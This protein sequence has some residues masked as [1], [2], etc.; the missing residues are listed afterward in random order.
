MSQKEKM[1]IM[2]VDDE[3]IILDS[4][5]KHFRNEDQYNVRTS[6]TVEEALEMIKEKPVDIIL[7]DLMMPEID[8]LEF[9]KMFKQDNPN[10]IMIMITGYAT[11]NSALQAMQVGAFDYIAKPFTREEL[12]KVIARAAEIVKAASENENDNN[13]SRMENGKIKGIGRNSWLMQL[14]DGHVLIGVERSFLLKYGKIQ[15]I[16]LPDQGDEI[17]Q[18]SSYFQL[19]S[20][21][22]RSENLLCPISGIVAQTNK[23]VINNPN[24]LLEDPYEEGWLIKLKPT[25]FEKEIKL[26]GL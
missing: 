2:V 3:Q 21:D 25:D 22:L 8:G 10:T 24:I 5:T 7:T 12:K 18:G 9:I 16:Y 4:V 15:T 1:E 14:E 20:S 26:I 6:L 23:K 19:F 11:I 17:R 13:P